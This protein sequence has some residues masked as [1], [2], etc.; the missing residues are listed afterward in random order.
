MFKVRR[1][2]FLKKLQKTIDKRFSKFYNV[3]NSGKETKEDEKI[4]SLYDEYVYVAF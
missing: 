3:E 4:F 2:T 1:L